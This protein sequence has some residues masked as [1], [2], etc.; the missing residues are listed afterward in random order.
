MKMKR[1][2]VFGSG[3]A[4]SLVVIIAVATVIPALAHNNKPSG[5]TLYTTGGQVLLQLPPGTPTYPPGPVGHPTALRIFVDD[6]DRRSAFGAADVMLVSMWAPA[7]N[8][9]IPVV[10]ISDNPDPA[11]SALIKAAWAGIISPQN[12]IMVADNELE[13]WKR[14]DVVTANLTKAIDV[15]FTNPLFK[16][17]NFTLQPTAIEFRGIDDAYR[18]PE[19]TTNLLS[20]Y[21]VTITSIDKP[22]WVR[23]R[24]PAWLGGQQ[25][26][27]AGVLN[28]HETMTYIPPPPAP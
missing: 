18:E 6:V 8:K 20:G 26:E 7:Y 13:V 24:I 16:A 28:L 1:S 9:F 12:V 19:A 10:Y 25:I 5:P 21:K 17:Y 15:K 4:L 2:I 14:G 3:L 23:V 22:A 27:F 11:F